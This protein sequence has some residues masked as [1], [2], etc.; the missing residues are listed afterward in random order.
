MFIMDLI[1]SCA[2]QPQCHR[3]DIFS[4][5]YSYDAVGNRT[6]VVEAAGDRVT[7]SYDNLYQLL[8]EQRSGVHAHHIAYSYDPVGNRLTST[9]GGV[10][11]TSTYN[12]ANE[13]VKS[14]GRGGVTTYT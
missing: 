14:Q 3:D 2:G 11:T 6:A 10:R 5:D 1:G 13:L 7:W 4:F 9:N 12:S 8:N